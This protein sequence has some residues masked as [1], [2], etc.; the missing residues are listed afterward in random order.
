MENCGAEFSRFVGKYPEGM[1]EAIVR[2]VSNSG[3]EMLVTVN[4]CILR[5]VSE[6]IPIIQGHLRWTLPLRGREERSPETIWQTSSRTNES[7]LSSFLIARLNMNYI[8]GCQ[9]HRD[10]TNT[11]SLIE[12]QKHDVSV[13]ERMNNVYDRIIVRIEEE[14]TLSPKIRLS[15]D[16]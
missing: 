11:L 4:L 16:L 12:Q 7:N 15:D 5:I 3:K 2:I 13:N 10:L 8:L 1:S 9:T 6:R 14:Q